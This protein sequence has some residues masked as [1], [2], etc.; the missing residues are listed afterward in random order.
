MTQSTLLMTFTVLMPTL[1]ETVGFVGAR[2]WSYFR[3]SFPIPPN[4]ASFTSP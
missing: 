2:G 3:Q 1:P 4:P